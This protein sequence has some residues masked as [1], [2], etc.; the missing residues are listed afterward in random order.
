MDWRG[1]LGEDVVNHIYCFVY[2]QQHKDLMGE[3]C[4]CIDH[5]CDSET[6][7]LRWWHKNRLVQYASVHRFQQYFGNHAIQLNSLKLISSQ[8][9]LTD[10]VC[11]TTKVS[12]ITLDDL[13]TEISR[14][15]SSNS[16]VRITQRSYTY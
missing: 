1:W 3:L 16:S 11:N 6:S 15:F 14:S 8:D 12:D 2:R 7:N 10:A 4:E 13:T 9:S 5:D